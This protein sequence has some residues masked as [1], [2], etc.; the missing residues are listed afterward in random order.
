MK[1]TAQDILKVLLL[2]LI[3]LTLLFGWNIDLNSD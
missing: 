1:W 3:F 2:G